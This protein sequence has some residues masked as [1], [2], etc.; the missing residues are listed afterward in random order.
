M[1]QPSFVEWF[2]KLSCI[3]ILRLFTKVFKCKNVASLTEAC[4]NSMHHK[5]VDSDE[6]YIAY[7]RVH[8]YR[9]VNRFSVFEIDKLFIKFHMKE[10]NWTLWTAVEEIVHCDLRII[11]N[12]LCNFFDWSSIIYYKIRVIYDIP[13][14][15]SFFYNKIR[16]LK[17]I[18]LS[19]FC[20]N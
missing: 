2:F 20:R 3:E 9:I 6:L 15:F 1:H 18:V 13:A 5:W 17:A 8:E 11:V 4:F 14:P 19:Y 7:L 16:L 12:A 10:S